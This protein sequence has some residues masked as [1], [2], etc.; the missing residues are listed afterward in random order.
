MRSSPYSSENRYLRIPQE[1]IHVGGRPGR[2][3]VSLACTLVAS[4]VCRIPAELLLRQ[5]SSVTKS[6]TVLGS[7]VVHEASDAEAPYAHTHLAWLWERA[8]NL[9]GARLMYVECERAPRSILMRSTANRSSGC[10]WCS[11][12]TTQGTSSAPP[13]SQPLWRRLLGLGSNCRRASSGTT[14]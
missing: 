9:H 14:T 12:G 8:P 6:N 7:S 11:R 13:A 10:S 1:R 2:R 3:H 4:H 5:L